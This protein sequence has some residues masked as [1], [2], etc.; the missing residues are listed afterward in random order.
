MWGK[1]KRIEEFRNLGIGESRYWRIEKF[2]KKDFEQLK[3][4]IN[5]LKKIEFLQFLNP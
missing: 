5:K 4:K 2:V 1:S 3:D